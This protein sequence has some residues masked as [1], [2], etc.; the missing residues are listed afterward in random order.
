[1]SV[2]IGIFRKRYGNLFIP[3]IN[4]L[5]SKKLR[6]NSFIEMHKKNLLYSDKDFFGKYGFFH[7]SE[8]I[9][10]E[11]NVFRLSVYF[12]SSGAAVSPVCTGYGL[13]VFERKGCEEDMEINNRF[14]KF[15]IQELGAGPITQI[16]TVAKFWQLKWGR[17]YLGIKQKNDTGPEIG[18]G[19]QVKI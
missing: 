12:L 4:L 6:K 15:L 14:E 16:D 13:S 8:P 19:W 2:K 18:I 5:I 11:G 3:S 7:F 17:V 10:I 1:M 9:E